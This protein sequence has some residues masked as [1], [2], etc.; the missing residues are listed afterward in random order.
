MCRG[1]D[2]RVTSEPTPGAFVTE[3]AWCHIHVTLD[4]YSDGIDNDR[5]LRKVNP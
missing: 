5:S 3:A 4:F 2:A 1:H